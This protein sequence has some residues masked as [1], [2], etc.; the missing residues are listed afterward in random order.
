MLVFSSI[1][2]VS[3]QSD[4]SFYISP[5]ASLGFTFAGGIAFGFDIDVGIWRDHLGPERE[6]NT[7]ISYTSYWTKA[8]HDRLHHIGAISFMAESD[9][10]DIKVGF[11]KVVDRHGYNHIVHCRAYGMYT[12]VSVTDDRTYIPWVGLKGFWYDWKSFEG[13]EYPYITPYVKYK[14][15]FLQRS[16]IKNFD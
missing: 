1:N 4:N 14:Y 10:Y 3:A 12:D 7:G 11:G 5:A 6:L 13:F 8:Y 16:G 9:Y 2:K 15:D